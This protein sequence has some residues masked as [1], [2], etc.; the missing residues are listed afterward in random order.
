[1]EPTGS[2]KAIELNFIHDV[3]EAPIDATAR[4]FSELKDLGYFDL[5]ALYRQFYDPSVAL[6][7]PSLLIFYI[8]FGAL[9]FWVNS[10]TLRSNVTMQEYIFPRRILERR[11]F[12]IDIQWYVLTLLG[13]LSAF[14]AFLSL[15]ILVGFASNYLSNIGYDDLYVVR[16]ARGLMFGLPK[17]LR[18]LIFFLT[19]VVTLDFLVYWFHRMMHRV[20]MLWNFHK[21]HHYPRQIT[22]LANWRVHPVEAVLAG[23]IDK[24]VVLAAVVLWTPLYSAQDIHNPEGMFRSQVWVVGAALLIQNFFHSFNHTT[25]YISYGRLL[26]KVLYSPGLHLIHHARDFPNKNFAGIFSLWDTLFGTL[27]VPKNIDEHHRIGQRLGVKSMADDHYKSVFHA[28]AL[29]FLDCLPKRDK[30][31]LLPEETARAQN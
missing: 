17:G 4:A 10:N 11:S 27:Y 24:L 21:V 22:F 20:P 1:M 8:L 30:A 28:I 13:V 12:W 14:T 31:A 16:R 23:F 19:V 2:L 15:L 29:P 9:I 18:S 6:L 7:K 26:D 5:S 3:L 25:L